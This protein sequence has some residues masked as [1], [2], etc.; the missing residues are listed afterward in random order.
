MIWARI[1]GWLLTAGAV[2]AVL[3]GAYAVGGRAARRSADLRQAQR[4]AQQARAAQQAQEGARRTRNEIDTEV[5][6]LPAGGAAERLR[7][8]Y[9]RD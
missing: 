5:R 2:L 3:V 7:T 4:E 1:Q 9:S 6:S 8:K